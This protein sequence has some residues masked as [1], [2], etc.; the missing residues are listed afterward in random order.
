[1]MVVTAVVPAPF[2]PITFPFASKVVVTTT[3]ALLPRLLVVNVFRTALSY[4]IEIALKPA[5]RVCVPTVGR[6]KLSQAV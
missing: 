6:P 4:E 1:M 5:P 2:K 3:G